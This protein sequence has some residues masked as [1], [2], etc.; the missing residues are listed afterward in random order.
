VRALSQAIFPQSSDTRANMFDA[1]AFAHRANNIS[2]M[3]RD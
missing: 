3:R 2:V 1:D